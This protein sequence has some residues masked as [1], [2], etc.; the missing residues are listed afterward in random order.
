MTYLDSV[1]FGLIACRE[2]LPDAEQIAQGFSN[3]I[4]AL[5]KA[6]LGENPAKEPFEKLSAT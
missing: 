3:G 2:S 1:D 5:T 6:A 4:D